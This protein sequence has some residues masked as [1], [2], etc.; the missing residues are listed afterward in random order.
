MQFTLIFQLSKSNIG[1]Y[2][3]RRVIKSPIGVNLIGLILFNDIYYMF[4]IYKYA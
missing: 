4:T 3:F 1:G 2:M